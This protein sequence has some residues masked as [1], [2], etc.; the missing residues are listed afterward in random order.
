MS[1]A[2]LQAVTTVSTPIPSAVRDSAGNLVDLS[3][4]VWRLGAVTASRSIYWG[5]LDGCDDDATHALRFYVVHMIQTVSPL[6]VYNLSDSVIRYLQAVRRSGAPSHVVDIVSLMWHL[7]SLREKRGEF[8]FH[9]IRAWYQFATDNFLDGFDDDTLFALWDLRIKGNEKGIA[10]LS[11]DPEDGPLSA[12]EEIALRRA[13][14]ADT[15]SIVERVA[16]W[17]FLAFGFNP[18][19]LSLM[20]EEDFVEYTFAGVQPQFEL[21][22]PRIKK[23]SAPRVQFKR[24]S[25]QPQLAA[26]VKELVEYNRSIRKEDEIPRPLFSRKQP[27][28][29]KL[30]NDLRP[31]AYHMTSSEITNLVQTCVA[32]LGVISPRTGQPLRV[33]ARRLRYTFAS[34]M[35]RQ[36]VPPRDLADLLDHTDTQHVLVYYKADSRFVERLDATIAI[37]L[38][39]LVKAFMGEIVGRTHGEDRDIITLRD[40]PGLGK[41]TAEFV[42]GLAPVRSCYPCAKFRPFD[43][44]PHLLVLESYV[45]ERSEHLASGDDR[46]AEQLDELILSVGEVVAKTMRQPNGQVGGDEQE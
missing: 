38:G 7:Q 22:V 13:L 23:R 35:A 42:C 24:R 1:R 12:I 8:C 31:Y 32:R 5:R 40:L 19:N 2:I 14:M 9:H 46:M 25:L 10:V 30:K 34:K 26:L 36:G 39:P 44:G 17:L 11:S 43:D 6:Y 3:G 20:R 21:N 37:E 29:R 27:D 15:G 18:A 28:R 4:S 33:T 16:T 45:K 41:C